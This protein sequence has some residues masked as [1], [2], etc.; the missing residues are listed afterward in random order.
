[1]DL[2]HQKYCGGLCQGWLV[3]VLRACRAAQANECKQGELDA[4]TPAMRASSYM[5]HRR[6]FRKIRQSLKVLHHQAGQSKPAQKS[7]QQWIH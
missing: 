7:V 6:E 3:K 4:Q 1:V 5:I 2:A